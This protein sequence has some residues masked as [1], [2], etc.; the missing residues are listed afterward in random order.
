MALQKEE[1]MVL[2][3]HKRPIGPF[4]KSQNVKHAINE[5]NSAW[6]VRNQ[7]PIVA[8]DADLDEHLKEDAMRDHNRDK[9]EEQNGTAGTIIGSMLGAIGGCL[10]AIGILTLPG[11]GLLIAVDASKTAP[12]STLAGAGIG[13]VYGTLIEALSVVEI[14]E[15]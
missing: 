13:A 12:A 2:D 4:T 11:I 10:V 14:S 1:E 5:L 6:Y 9:A 7:I 3:E 15:D 8:K